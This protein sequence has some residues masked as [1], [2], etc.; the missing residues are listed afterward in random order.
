MLHREKA[1]SAFEVPQY[2]LVPLP[3]LKE[4]IFE[5]SNVPPYIFAFFGILA[6]L[7]AVLKNGLP[8]IVMPVLPEALKA[9]QS[10]L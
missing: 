10:I 7:N 3:K 4:L 1:P 6:F 8:D 2:I 9:L 5:L